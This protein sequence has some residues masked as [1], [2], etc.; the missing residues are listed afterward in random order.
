MNMNLQNYVSIYNITDLSICE[1]VI[2]TLDNT[3]WTKHYYN[4]NVKNTTKTYD[5]DLM[6][7]IKAMT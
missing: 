2:Q 4:N 1:K 3:K 6:Y 7:L 5:D